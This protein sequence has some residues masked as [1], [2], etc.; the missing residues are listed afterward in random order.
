MFPFQASCKLFTG[1]LKEPIHSQGASDGYVGGIVLPNDGISAK[2]ATY[3]TIN[4]LP[5]ARLVG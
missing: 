5:H 1:R 2:F 3:A 4:V